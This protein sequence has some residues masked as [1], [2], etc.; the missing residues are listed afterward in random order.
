VSGGGDFPYFRGYSVAATLKPAPR[1]STPHR[2]AGFPRLFSRGHIEAPE[3][4]GV[5]MLI[6]T[7]PRLFSRGHI[8]A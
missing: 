1:R 7:F 6:E 2:L 5:T 8:E 3:P 4:D